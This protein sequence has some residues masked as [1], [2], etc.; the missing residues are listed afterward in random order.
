MMVQLRK[1]GEQNGH[2]KMD[3]EVYN[4]IKKCNLGVLRK[5]QKEELPWAYF[6]CYRMT[7]DVFAAAELLRKAWLETV[8]MIAA[9]GGCPRDSF[10]SC[11]ARTLYRVCDTVPK[12]EDEDLL[13]SFEVPR[14]AQK[15]DFFIEEI[16]RMEPSERKIYLLFKLGD[17]GN[18]EFSDILHIPLS[19]AKEYLC[20]LEKKAHPQESESAYFAL[21]RLLNEFKGANKT[22]FEQINIPELFINTLEHD[23][24][25]IFNITAGSGK[26]VKRK[27]SDMKSTAKN[28]AKPIVKLT[29]PNRRAAAKKKKTIIISC[30]AAVLV[31][32]FIITM[33]AVAKKANTPSSSYFYTYEV[34]A[35]T[36]GNVNTTISGSG[37]LTPVTSKTLT[38]AELLEPLSADESSA[39]GEEDDAQEKSYDA[40]NGSV[41]GLTSGAMGGMPSIGSEDAAIPEI[42]GGTIGTVN[43]QAGDTVAEGDVLAVIVFESE[44]SEAEAET[45]NILAPYNAVILEWYLR[46][47]AEITDETSVG[48]FLGT[49]DGYTMTISVDENNISLIKIGQ[50]VEISIDVSSEEM[51]TGAVTDISYNGSTGGSTTAY[52]ITVNFDYVTGTYPGMS[53]SA[54]IVIEDSGEGLLVP[55]SAIRTSGD[56]KYVYLAPSGTTLG[57]TYDEGDIDLS[58]LT[59]VSVTEG[60]SDGSYTMIESTSLEEGDKVLVITAD[61]TQTG[62]ASSGGSGGGMGSFGSF[63]GGSFPG[64]DF[65]FGSFDP[66]QFGGSFPFAY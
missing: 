38:V 58:K 10:R 40:E 45:R 47:G 49:D 44:D 56:T 31:I 7:K 8:S 25:K 16:D 27:D 61:S 21:M 4:K 15:F 13:S 24:N 62:S 29:Q 54:E 34:Q 39:S 46:E 22:L 55:V 2:K 1:N 51:P 6:V 53:V 23:Y 9:L 30:V 3:Y 5:L 64:G 41:S 19:K 50:E 52:K 11:L 33:V 20:D 14:I 32:A 43:V 26:T 59:K 48:M 65:D 63:G 57:E 66:S 17:L 18:A 12:V 37:S 28:T 36:V 60:M 42:V 35:V